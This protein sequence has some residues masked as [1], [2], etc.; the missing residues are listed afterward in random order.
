MM[1]HVSLLI[2]AVAA[3]SALPS[4]SGVD[5]EVTVDSENVG[6][7]VK[8]DGTTHT[9]YTDDLDYLSTSGGDVD[10]FVG[11]RNT[12][13][14]NFNDICGDT[15]CGSD[16][17][18]LQSLT[19]T[20]S[21]SS[22]LGNIHACTW[23]FGGSYATVNASTGALTVHAKTFVCKIPVKSGTTLKQLMTTLTAAGTTKP[24]DRPLPGLTTTIYDAI[25][26][27]CLP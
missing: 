15:F 7:D 19:F 14:S 23:T 9:T 22:K 11:L 12:L 25:G 24:I 2:L 26:T 5:S 8:G 27:N 10:G 4:D 3:C 20:C 16:Y 21:V 18:D 17:G 6:D 1:R 13:T